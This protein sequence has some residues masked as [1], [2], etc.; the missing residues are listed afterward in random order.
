MADSEEK[1]PEEVQV[2]NTP[3]TSITHTTSKGFTVRPIDP[4]T[5]KFVKKPTKKASTEEVTRIGREFLN[6]RVEKD[7]NGNI[8][9]SS[10]T[11]YMQWLEVLND[12][13]MNS[14]GTNDAKMVMA[15]G[16][17]FKIITERVYGPARDIDIETFKTGV[18]IV[19]L[20]APELPNIGEI[21]PRD[22]PVPNFIEGEFITD[23]KPE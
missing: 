5:H 6:Q 19:V 14:A 3:V 2:E 23:P 21:Q 7:S 22:K 9:K 10:K 11:R 13:I 8:T 16:S 20:T 17:L 12:H 15:A 18:K 4:I 1:K